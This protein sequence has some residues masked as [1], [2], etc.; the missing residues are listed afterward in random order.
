MVETAPRSIGEHL[1]ILLRDLLAMCSPFRATA[2]T[3][4]VKTGRLAKWTPFGF[5]PT[6]AM[7]PLTFPLRSLARG[8]RLRFRTK[9]ANWLPR[10]LRR[11]PKSSCSGLCFAGEL[12]FSLFV[13]RVKGPER[14]V[15]RPLVPTNGSG[16]FVRSLESGV[17]IVQTGA[18]FQSRIR[19]FDGI[20]QDEIA[21]AG[22]LSWAFIRCFSTRRVI[23]WRPILT[24]RTGRK[25]RALSSKPAGGSP[26]Q[27]LLS[28]R[29]P[30]TGVTSGSSLQT[31]S[32]QA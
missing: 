17:P 22:I 13:S 28:V 7:W 19:S 1:P 11:R 30:G 25:M 26:C 5:V 21:E 14:V 29:A 15:I 3:G 18:L 10:I 6:L 12:T 27:R 8:S 20:F 16:A 32:P 2:Q 9:T 31:P 23:S 24:G 4:G